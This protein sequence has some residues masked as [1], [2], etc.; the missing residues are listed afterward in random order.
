MANW[1]MANAILTSKNT[2][3]GVVSTAIQSILE[4]FI[5]LAAA[6]HYSLIDL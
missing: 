1:C 5:Y 3:L 2:F 6:T 4:V